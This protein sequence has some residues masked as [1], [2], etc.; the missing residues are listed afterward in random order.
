[1]GGGTNYFKVSAVVKFYANAYF[2]ISACCGTVVRIDEHNYI[3]RYEANDAVA[4]SSSM[5]MPRIITEVQFSRFMA[6]K[7]PRWAGFG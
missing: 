5:G 7:N 6:R 1:M 4:S 2:S 3:I